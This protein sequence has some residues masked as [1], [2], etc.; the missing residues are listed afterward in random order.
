MYCDKIIVCDDGSVDDTANVA[1]SEGATV[2]QHTKNQGY[3][4]AIKTLFNY[5]RKEKFPVFV[6]LD[7][8]G[9]HDASDIPKIAEP[10][11]HGKAEIV[12]GSR[13]LKEE[14]KNFRK[15][16][17]QKLIEITDYLIKQKVILQEII[18]IHITKIFSLKYLNLK[19]Q[20][21]MLVIFILKTFLIRRLRE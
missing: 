16:K 14:H 3:G 20:F 15:N 11:F 17:K 19:N 6:T 9:Q 4:S 2:I 1:R 21:S 12:I 10:I 8:D 5:A 13:F 18:H 7:S